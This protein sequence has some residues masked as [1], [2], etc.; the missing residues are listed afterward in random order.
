MGP[1]E[2]FR[3]V[4]EQPSHHRVVSGQLHNA[5]TPA[6]RPLTHVNTARCVLELDAP[7]GSAGAPRVTDIMV[8]GQ[9]SGS[10]R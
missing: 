9:V 10:D 4:N 8:W 3:S 1:G 7:D 6:N 5:Q 2:R